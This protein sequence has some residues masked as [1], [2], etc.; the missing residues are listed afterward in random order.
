MPEIHLKS[1][2]PCLCIALFSC[3]GALPPVADDTATSKPSAEWAGSNQADGVET[4]TAD[5]A[6]LPIIAVLHS[7]E[8]FD[9][10]AV[11]QSAKGTYGI[12]QK[13]ELGDADMTEITLNIAGT[14]EGAPDQTEAPIA[15]EP[16]PGGSTKVQRE[17]LKVYAPGLEKEIRYFFLTAAMGDTDD[18]WQTE[19]FSYTSPEGKEGSYRVSCEVATDGTDGEKHARRMFSKIGILKN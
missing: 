16:S 18:T 15:S 12:F 4:E 2:T 6:K 14:P 11:Y 9:K 5:S 10:P 8:K 1:I 3:A 17:W 7:G 13:G 19:I